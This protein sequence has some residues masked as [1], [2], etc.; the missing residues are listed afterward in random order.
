MYVHRRP[1]IVHHAIDPACTDWNAGRVRFQV[2]A[3]EASG[4]GEKLVGTGAFRRPA[5]QY[6]TFIDTSIVQVA[7]V[8]IFSLD[9]YG[10]HDLRIRAI[11]QEPDKGSG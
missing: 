6:A 11:L 7:D 4:D 9:S 2:A 5:Y 1:Y 8:N 3:P 10:Q